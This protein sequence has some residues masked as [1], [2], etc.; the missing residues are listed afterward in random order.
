LD[1]TLIAL[2]ALQF[3]AT[4]SAAGAVFFRACV[5]EPAFRAAAGGAVETAAVPMLRFRIATIAW[6]SLGFV[7]ASSLGWLAVETAQMS[8]VSLSALSGSA[9]WTVLS[10]TNFGS[11]WLARLLIMALF[12]AALLREARRPIELPRNNALR[13]TLAAVLVGSLAFAGHAAA[14][15][16]IEGSIHLVSDILHL[17]GA[18]AWLGAL[19]PLAALLGPAQRKGEPALEVARIATLRFST[20]GIVSV[21]TLLA[22]GI[23][24]SWVL[25]G[26]VS[27]L[28]ETDYGRLLVLKI[29][30]FLVMLS[31]AAIN[32]TRLTPRLVQESDVSAARGA[33]RQLR[34]NCMIEMALGAIILVIVGALGTLPPAAHED[35]AS[36]PQADSGGAVMVAAS[37]TP[38]MRAC[39]SDS[40]F[41]MTTPAISPERRYDNHHNAMAVPVCPA[42]RPL[43]VHWAG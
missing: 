42:E 15:E 35:V 7:I 12:A 43:T 9:A 37:I 14:G 24:N 28:F 10:D 13:V 30:L 2:R 29:A 22:T 18:A 23:I 39:T 32:R 41:M 4:V 16:G 8:D 21:G 38:R 27:A 11:V 3:A 1:D 36:P 17:F 6:T 25:V 40:P 26:G 19:L 34:I 33:M 31:V 20:L 5:A